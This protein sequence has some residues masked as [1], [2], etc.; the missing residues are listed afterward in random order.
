MEG[1]K[2]AYDGRSV[3]G[4]RTHRFQL[5]LALARESMRLEVRPP[6]G[7]P[8]L[9]VTADGRRLLALDLAHRRAELWSSQP[10]GVARLIGAALGAGDLKTLLEGRSPCTGQAIDGSAG[11]GCA[12][13]GGRYLPVAAGAGEV[14]QARLLDRAGAPVL[15]L[16]YPQPRPSEGDWRKTIVLRRPADGSTLEL[17][18]DSGPT[19]AVLDPAI[20]S[21]ERPAGFETGEVLGADGLGAAVG[22]DP[23]GHE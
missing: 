19:P 18:L 12:F 3:T 17:T 7:G 13:G 14:Q 8:R 1:L 6:I 21:T 2:V 16:E 5:A 20:F 11:G 4:N 23:G 10:E 22:D 9:V 15:S